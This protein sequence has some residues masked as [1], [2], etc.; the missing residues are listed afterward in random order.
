LRLA[1]GNPRNGER[2]RGHDV[3]AVL[4]LV[5][6]QVL[7]RVD[8]PIARSAPSTLPRFSSPAPRGPGRKTAV[9]Q[10]TAAA[11]S[12]GCLPSRPR[13]RSPPPPRGSVLPAP[14]AKILPVPP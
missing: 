2:A 4:R 6:E 14:G 9:T 10:P 5:D 7:A 8:G 13:P 12:C 11:P 1:P 3:A